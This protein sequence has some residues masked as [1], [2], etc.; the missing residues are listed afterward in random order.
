MQPIQQRWQPSHPS[1]PPISVV[2][3][4]S[5]RPRQNTHPSNSDT[6]HS[7]PWP[8]KSFLIPHLPQTAKPPLWVP[9]NRPYLPTLHCLWA[10]CFGGP[11]AFLLHSYIC[12]SP[13][14]SPIHS[15]TTYQCTC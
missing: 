9:T 2:E 1:P 14:S 10:H 7:S 11:A 13:F 15:L 5:S 3:Q 6:A 8:Y 4:S 12:R